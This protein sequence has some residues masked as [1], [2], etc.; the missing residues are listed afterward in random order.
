MKNA[1]KKSVVLLVFIGFSEVFDYLNT[2]I[3]TY[4]STLN[5]GT[6]SLGLECFL[7]VVEVSEKPDKLLR[8]F[9]FYGVHTKLYA[10]LHWQLYSLILRLKST[11]KVRL[12]SDVAK[13]F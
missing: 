1:H 8:F 10:M 11:A 12:F 4:K 6:P 3:T 2:P 7:E 13:L 9:L 5:A